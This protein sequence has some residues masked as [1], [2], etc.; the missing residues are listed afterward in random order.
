M[1][2]CSKG[3]NDSREAEGAGNAPDADEAKPAGFGAET[4]RL[5]RFPR[6]ELANAGSR[7]SPTFTGRRCPVD[8]P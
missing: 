3:G 2:P 7:R 6:T 4:Q 1:S 8:L 5:E